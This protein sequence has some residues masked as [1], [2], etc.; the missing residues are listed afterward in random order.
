MTSS[1]E[2]DVR[3]AGRARRDERINAVNA[4]TSVLRGEIRPPGE[5][6]AL[7]MKLMDFNEFGFARRLLGRVR[8]MDGWLPPR[9]SFVKVG[10][11]HA[12]CTY[13]D[14]DL[15]ASD[16]FQRALEILDELDPLR[17][18]PAEEKESCGLRGAIFKRRWQIQGQA[19]DLEQAFGWYTKGYEIGRSVGPDAA[20]GLEVAL[21]CGYTGINAAY[22]LDLLTR[23]EARRLG[24]IGVTTAAAAQRYRTAQEIRRR[25]VAVLDP[26]EAPSGGERPAPPWWLQAT[27]AE[28]HLGVGNFDDAIESLRAF[29]RAKGL[30]PGPPLTEV[31]PWEFES[32]ITQLVSLAD[33]QG[34]ITGRLD[35]S[36]LPEAERPKFSGD[37][38]RLRAT[39]AL[40]SY[41]GDK[42]PLVDRAER[43]KI[44]LALSG[45]GFRASL[46]HIGVLAYLAEKDLL[47]HVEVLSCV[48]G[49]SIVGTHAYLEIRR[50]LQEKAD[51]DIT[52]SDYV[53][54]VKRVER[55]FL[56]G[57]QRNIRCHAYGSILANLRALIQPSYTTT[58]KLGDLYERFLFSRVEG[59]RKDWKR[60][61]SD[62][63]V[64][65]KGED[66][67][68]QPKYD[69]W[70]RST[71]VPMLVLNATTLNT[72]H[73][74]QF[75]ASWMGEPPISLDDEI[76]ANYRLR[77]MYYHEAPI[78]RDRW[79]SR[80]LRAFAPPDYR[81]FRLG[82]AV[83]ASSCVPGLFEPLMLPDLYP[84]K[85]VRLVDGGVFDNQGVASLLEQDCNGMIVSDASGQTESDDH[86]S[87]SRLPVA[88]RSFSVSMERVREAQFRELAARQRSGLLKKLAFMH[89]KKD[90]DADPVNWRD[91]Q[92]PIEASDE[93]R[94]A[95]SR[96]VLTTYGMQK[97]IQDL[98]SRIRTDLDS[99]TDLEA[100]ALM[101]SGYRQAATTCAS[102]GGSNEPS[103]PWRFRQV[104]E[105]L[106]QS[107]ESDRPN[108]HFEEVS[109][110]LKIGS[111]TLF[112]VWRTSRTLGVIGWAALF[113]LAGAVALLWWSYWNVPVITY[114]KLGLTILLGALGLLLPQLV[115]L[116]RYRQTIRSFGLRSVL[117]IVLAL[118]IR[119][120]LVTFDRL[121]L[122]LGGIGRFVP[123]GTARAGE[124]SDGAG[125]A[126]Q[127]SVNRSALRPS[128]SSV[129]RAI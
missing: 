65:P 72:G 34:E 30:S 13:K 62:L 52:R 32:S 33:L 49:G 38:F 15:P 86:P 56:A 116:I 83:A 87:G 41:L 103:V 118:V 25:V 93:A 109:R 110:Q 71:K 45:G 126:S 108:L 129:S 127:S 61:V 9:P 14:P 92:D 42:A 26:S 50:L 120:H 35:L 20:K 16:R 124:R 114:G 8:S 113:G 89:L 95:S 76:E 102:L 73:N 67:L 90:L 57:I 75:T 84:G 60:Y 19:A 91:C 111:G 29:N 40:R 22:V 69:N 100:F 77:R 96:C 37:Q 64:R 63:F 55:D 18:E 81:H 36:V 82:E 51:R 43:G 11:Q 117:R 47:R 123:K 7:A 106:R 39:D 4:A 105:L 17:M 99:F 115:A 125:D 27:L 104:D 80:L 70:R 53:E 98:L 66:E 24:S 1:P 112:K 2:S 10:Q 78:L 128:G 88:L 28:A 46:F 68:F 85:A 79:R 107:G 122:Y 58:R 74:W 94:P 23:E 3:A 44:G 119:L 5:I 121:F 12:L 21:D 54:I 97:S 31:P 101:Q 6:Y 59:N 48:S